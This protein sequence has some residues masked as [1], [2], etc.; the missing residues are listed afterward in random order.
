MIHTVT[1]SSC[2]EI[3]PTMSR[4]LYHMT[5][6]RAKLSDPELKQI[7]QSRLKTRLRRNGSSHYIPRLQIPLPYPPT[8]S[9]LRP[10]QSGTP[11][12]PPTPH[13]I[14]NPKLTTYACESRTFLPQHQS[15]STASKLQANP[16]LLKPSLMT[17][18]R[19]TRGLHAM[20]A[21]QHDTLLKE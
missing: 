20:S 2:Q 8:A 14:M 1:Y 12:I 11:E 21:S 9:T 3:G 10:P 6:R 18:R 15:S 19:H 4:I 7:N 16:S 5:R 17:H 13:H